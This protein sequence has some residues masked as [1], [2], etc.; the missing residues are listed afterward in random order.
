MKLPAPLYAYARLARLDKPTGIWLLLFP[1]WWSQLLNTAHGGPV[2]AMLMLMFF[3]G[4]VA[5]RAA[6]CAVNDVLDREL[7]RKV[8]R[9]K[10]R[11]VASGEISV[12]GALIFAGVMTLIGLAVVSQMGPLALILAAASLPLVLIYPLMKRFTWWP[13]AFLGLTFNWGALVASAALKN[14]ITFPS[15][16]LYAA[17]FFWTLGYDTVYAF[18]DAG[19]DVKAGIKS[20]ARLLGLNARKWVGFWYGLFWI[21][22]VAAGLATHMGIGFYV[23]MS[24]TLF[25]IATLI[26][27]WRM[28]DAHSSLGIFR[29]NTLLGWCVVFS[30]VAGLFS[31]L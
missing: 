2:D 4:S 15:L 20:T 8:A 30:F 24:L 6:G 23:G 7:D 16:I 18:Q 10:T 1:A 5:M 26:R 28:D 12:A 14:D 27:L 29:A 17:G 11:P 19:D 3:I 22:L 31:T 21:L 13:Q 9:T 25:E